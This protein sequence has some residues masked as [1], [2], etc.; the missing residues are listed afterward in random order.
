MNV[1]GVSFDSPS[2]NEKFAEKESFTFDLWSDTDRTLA[3]YYGAASSA[4]QYFADRY[5]YILDEN[6]TLVL[7]YE[8]GGNGAPPA[9]VLEDCQTLFGP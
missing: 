7:Q 8:D 2:A 6:G 9:D 4:D 1:V 3:M 5:T